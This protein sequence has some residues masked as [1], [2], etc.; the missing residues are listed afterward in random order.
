[1]LTKL[2]VNF[3]APEWRDGSSCTVISGIFISPHEIHKFDGDLVRN[4]LVKK[5]ASINGVVKHNELELALH[6]A[7]G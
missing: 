6:L 4:I 7:N 2:R 3:A 1:M 5:M